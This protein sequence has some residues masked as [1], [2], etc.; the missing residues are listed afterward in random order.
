MTVSLNPTNDAYMYYNPILRVNVN[1]Y[2]CH[3]RPMEALAM[4]RV[5]LPHGLACHIASTWVPHD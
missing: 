4:V 1:M 2:T 3:L 5:A